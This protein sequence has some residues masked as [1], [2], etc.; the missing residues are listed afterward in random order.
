MCV[1]IKAADCEALGLYDA[2]IIA[3]FIGRREMS[4]DEERPTKKRRDEDQKKSVSHPKLEPKTSDGVSVFSDKGFDM[5]TVFLRDVI[6]AFT[7][8]NALPHNTD[9]PYAMNILLQSVGGF[10]DT[11]N[12]DI[13]G[14]HQSLTFTLGWYANEVRNEN[15]N[16]TTRITNALWKYVIVTFTT[17][18][19]KQKAQFLTYMSG[20]FFPRL[21]RDHIFTY[22]RANEPRR[23]DQNALGDLKFF[24]PSSSEKAKVR[25]YHKNIVFEEKTPTE[26]VVPIDQKARKPLEQSGSTSGMVTQKRYLKLIEKLKQMTDERD[27]AE[28]ALRI[29][30]GHLKFELE[31]RNAVKGGERISNKDAAMII[32]Q[33]MEAQGKM[34]KML[35]MASDAHLLVGSF[36]P[37]LA[38]QIK[39]A[40][41]ESSRYALWSVTYLE[42]RRRDQ[43]LAVYAPR[44]NMNTEK[45]LRFTLRGKTLN[46]TKPTVLEDLE[47]SESMTFDHAER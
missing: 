15:W 4:K 46:E 21:V 42:D 10:M 11:D 20:F 45:P 13:E 47:P 35:L 5:M 28:E 43:G 34:W 23:P 33:T 31:S 38:A 22:S 27:R 26:N 17:T 19:W 16:A 32:Q 25:D 29:K 8:I 9:V 37:E 39:L 14:D 6:S 24:K 1:L 30:S 41:D 18:A 2:V 7:Q 3:I 40:V 36:P 44:Q 12:R